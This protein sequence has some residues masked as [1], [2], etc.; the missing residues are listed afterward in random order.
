MADTFAGKTVIVTG[1]SRG[2]GRAAAL[3]LAELGANVM[4]ADQDEERLK[5]AKEDFPIAKGTV[6]RFTCDISQKF[7]VNNLLAAT[8]DAFEKIDAV[9]TTISDFERGDPLTLPVEALDRTLALNLRSAFL[10]SQAAANKMIARAEAE[11]RDSASGAIVHVS[12]LSGQLS[13]PDIA[14][15]AISCA[16]LDQLTRSLAATLAPK[17][18]RVNG[19]APGG[20]MT[21]TLRRAVADDPQLRPALIARTP[22]GRIGE[23]AEA[24]EAALFL[25]SDRAS[26]ITGQILTIDGGRSVLDPLAAANM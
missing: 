14:A 26:F 23:A 9:I 1:A 8:L 11:G 25:A 17:G 19:V 24:A 20:V 15:H 16:A 13:S 7:G 6:A 2:V 3:R 10:L 12:S 5:A 22:L 4:L 21:D 18:L